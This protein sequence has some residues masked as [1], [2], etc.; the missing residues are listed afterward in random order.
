MGALDQL[1]AV[2]R[3]WHGVSGRGYKDLICLTFVKFFNKRDNGNSPAN[4]GS[5]LARLFSAKLPRGA[6]LQA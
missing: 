2:R 3:R 1:T 4:S 6:S 5:F